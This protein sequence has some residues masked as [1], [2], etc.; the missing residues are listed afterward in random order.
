[1]TPAQQETIEMFPLQDTA[2]RSS[3]HPRLRGGFRYAAL[4][5]ALVLVIAACGGDKQDPAAT[6]GQ[7][8]AAPTP[9]AQ[10]TT[11]VISA[12]IAA[13]SVDQLREAARAA[14]GEQRMYAPAGNNAMEYY[15]AL[16]DKQPNDAAVASALTDLMPYALIATEQSIGRDDFA[17][18]QRLYSLME[19]ADKAAPALPRLKQSLTDA[20]TTFAQRQQQTQLDAEAEK[21]RLA[22]LE[23]E[24]QKQQEDT[25]RQAAQQLAQQ[26]AAQQQAAQQATAQREAEQRAAAQREADQRAAAQREADQRAAA[27]AQTAKASATAGDLRAISTPSPRYPPE[28]LRAGQSG[29][30]LV[31]FTVAVDGSVSSAR[32]VRGNPPRVFDREAVAAVRRWRFQPVAAPVTTRRTL[33]FKPEG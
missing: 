2:S 29:E 5:A 20:Q 22:K 23:E 4:S 6:E 8:A 1:L 28:A 30:V 31:E 14:Q 27:Q 19:K 21:A 3:R 10:A 17:E 11:P 24:R 26:Q 16:R 15:L 18:A 33:G 25:Q 13:M 7:P 32:V 12:Q 9:T